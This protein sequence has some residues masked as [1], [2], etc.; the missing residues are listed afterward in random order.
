MTNDERLLERIRI[1]LAERFDGVI[2]AEIVD[3][4][5]ME[6]YQA[7][8][9]NARIKNFLP[10]MTEQMAARELLRLATPDQ[11]RGKPA[12]R[13][14]FLSRHDAG[15]SQMAVALMDRAALHA[16][17]PVHAESAG[18]EPIDHIEP[19]VLTAMNEI[20]LDLTIDHP[21]PLT[22][23]AIAAA[24]LVVRT[25]LSCPLPAGKRH[26][27]WPLADPG[28][29]PLADVRQIRDEIDVRVHDLLT[30]LQASA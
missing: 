28:H 7:L 3:R 24:D 19:L 16:I 29:R 20:G 11:Q 2:D 6:S 8:F 22:P 30:N 1:S 18:A 13:V 21:K 4:Q 25:D 14:L 17:H 27:D 15:R 23:K 5:V 26:L 9:R 10:V 12:P